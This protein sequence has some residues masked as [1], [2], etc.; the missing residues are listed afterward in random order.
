MTA[1]MSLAPTMLSK[2]SPPILIR[3][4]KLL[5]TSSVMMV[6]KIEHTEDGNKII[7]EAFKVEDNSN[8]ILPPA[9]KSGQTSCHP[10]CKSHIVAQVKHTD[11]L[12][13]DQFIDSRGEM[14]SQDEL[15]ICSV[16]NT[17]YLV[18]S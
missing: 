7:V 9:C 1:V 15:Q 10:F 3:S 18:A 5:S 8:A 4:A 13:L 12:I 14:Y 6:K 16:S 11:V 17:D 2:M